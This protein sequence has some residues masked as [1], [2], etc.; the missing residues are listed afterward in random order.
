[1]LSL[2]VPCKFAVSTITWETE[3]G[4]K[5]PANVYS[6]NKGPEEYSMTVANYTDIIKLRAAQEHTP[7]ARGDAYARIDLHASV[8]YAAK[9]ATR[10]PR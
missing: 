6:C 10:Q 7:A 1:M 5:L 3:Y 8:D 9:C 2:S 4:T